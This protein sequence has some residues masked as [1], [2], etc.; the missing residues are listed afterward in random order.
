MNAQEAIAQ[1]V[2]ATKPLAARYLAGFDDSNHTRQAPSLPNHVA[3]NLGHLAITMHRAADRIAGREADLTADLI[4]GGRADGGGDMLRFATESVS[5]GSR[6]VDDSSQYPRLA[7]CI[8][9]FNNAADRVAR[10]IRE[11]PDDQLQTP[12]PWGGAGMTIP[13]H[14]MASRMVFHNG[15]HVGQIADLRRALGFKSIFA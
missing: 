12:V 4:L 11:L 6:P 13:K 10:A 15:D 3:W 9:I 1:A 8:E 5:F 2:L 14:L 7:R